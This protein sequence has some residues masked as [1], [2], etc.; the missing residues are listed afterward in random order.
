MGKFSPSPTSHS[1]QSLMIGSHN[2]S[3]LTPTARLPV[4][5]LD[6]GINR[7]MPFEPLVELDGTGSFASFFGKNELLGKLRGCWPVP[8]QPVSRQ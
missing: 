7:G 8:R 3:W 5:P 1:S 2:I 6:V 4:G